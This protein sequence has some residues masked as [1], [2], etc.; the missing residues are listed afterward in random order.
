ML[1]HGYVD[2]INRTTY[3]LLMTPTAEQ[4]IGWIESISTIQLQIVKQTGESGTRYRI[5][6]RDDCLPFSNIIKMYNYPTR[7][8]ATLAAIDSALDYLIKNK[9]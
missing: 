4:M 8:E 3:T 5:W 2:S 9:K 6:V 7:R 1:K